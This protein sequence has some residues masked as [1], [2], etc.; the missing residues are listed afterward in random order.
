MDAIRFEVNITCPDILMAATVIAAAFKGATPEKM[1]TATIAAPTFPTPIAA[2]TIQA[3]PVTLP[4]T[5]A[6]APSVTPP[7]TVAPAPPVT[8]PLPPTATA[9]TYSMDQIANAGA[10]LIQSKP[11]KMD[12]LLGLLAQ[13]GVQA[14]TQLE[15]G[16]LG[17]FATA[18]RGLGAQI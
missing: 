4:A 16:H 14:I 1:P 5:V 12:A 10:A 11:E 6:P 8:P 18:L 13:Y 3:A 15:P 2:P 17:A 9:P 7:V